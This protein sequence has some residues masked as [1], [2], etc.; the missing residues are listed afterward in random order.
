MLALTLVRPENVQ[1][2]GGSESVVMA[3][4]KPDG[5]AQLSAREFGSCWHVAIT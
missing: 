4:V 2:G 5:M 1:A 3:I